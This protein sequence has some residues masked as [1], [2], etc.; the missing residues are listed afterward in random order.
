MAFGFV[1]DVT[2]F[3]IVTIL[4]IIFRIQLTSFFYLFP[5]PTILLYLLSALPFIVFE[6]FINCITCFPGT[7]YF[8]SFVMALLAAMI[9]F[10]KYTLIFYAVIGVIAFLIQMPYTTFI[11]LATLIILTFV[12]QSIIKKFPQ[13]KYVLIIIAFSI[14]GFI[15]ETFVSDANA[16]PLSALSLPLLL[17]MS[18]WVMLSYAF[19]AIVPLR[20]LLDLDGHRSKKRNKE[21]K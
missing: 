21:K 5:L 12:I 10:P 1:I 13:H 16:T 8:L 2:L 9:T 4:V 17:L 20:I 18:F 15:F 6:E 7:I 11:L 3:S 19:L 14:A